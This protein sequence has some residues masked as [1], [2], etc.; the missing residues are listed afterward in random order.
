MAERFDGVQRGPK[1]GPNSSINVWGDHPHGVA[2]LTSRRAFQSRR[3][4]RS[5]SRH[6]RCKKTAGECSWG[7][8]HAARRNLE[9]FMRNVRFFVALL[10]VISLS[11]LHA[12]NAPATTPTTAPSTQPRPLPKNIKADYDVQYVPDGDVAQRRIF[13]IPRSMRTN[14]CRCWSGFTAAD[15]SAG[16][17]PVARTLG[18]EPRVHRCQCGVSLQ[19]EGEISGAD[20]GLP[21]GHPLAPRH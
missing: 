2:S 16:T 21:G 18:S 6:E 5:R 14:R 19:P 1:T 4:Q 17:K 3:H 7:L 12:A 15:G 8:L 13:T 9:P 11:S 20:P 10:T